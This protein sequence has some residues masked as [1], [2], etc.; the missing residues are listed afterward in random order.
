MHGTKPVDDMEQMNGRESYDNWF[1]FP[2][3]KYCQC[4]ICF[5]MFYCHYHPSF[6]FTNGK[7]TYFAMH[8]LIHT[9]DTPFNMLRFS[10]SW[11]R[12]K[13]C[14]LINLHDHWIQ[15]PWKERPILTIK[16]VFS[17]WLLKDKI[18]VVDLE[19]PVTINKEPIAGTSQW[20]IVINGYIKSTKI[21]LT[22]CHVSLSIWWQFYI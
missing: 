16:K 19:S 12:S 17:H 8:N 5:C 22:F 7:I 20:E 18:H 11:V 21:T 2:S 10:Q 15:D 9:M 3:P 13:S 4:C 1:I 14:E 6:I